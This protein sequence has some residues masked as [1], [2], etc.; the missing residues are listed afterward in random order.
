MTRPA[1]PRASANRSSSCTAG[2]ALRP[3]LRGL[4][5]TRALLVYTQRN[6]SPCRLGAGVRRGTR[7]PRPVHHRLSRFVVPLL[8]GS[9]RPVDHL[10]GD[11]PQG[12]GA[13]LRAPADAWLGC[14]LLRALPGR[15]QGGR[16]LSAAPV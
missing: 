13:L 16:S 11:R 7:W 9:R 2:L 4:V 10:A 12:A 3:T 5:V 14:R 8:S 6:A 1:R 15:A